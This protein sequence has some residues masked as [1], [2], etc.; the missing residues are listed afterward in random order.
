MTGSSDRYDLVQHFVSFQE[1]TGT[2]A[3]VVL[4]YTIVIYHAGYITSAA[5]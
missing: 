5:L 1:K 4:A 2:V 3:E